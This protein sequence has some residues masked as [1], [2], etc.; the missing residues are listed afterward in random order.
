MDYARSLLLHQLLKDYQ[1][2]AVSLKVLR[3]GCQSE[4]CQLEEQPCQKL[5]PHRSHATGWFNRVFTLY[6][7]GL[8]T[9]D[10]LQIVAPPRAAQLWRDHVAPLDKVVRE[11]AHGPDAEDYVHPVE[12]FWRDYADGKLRTFGEPV[13]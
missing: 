7:F 2:V 4:T 3:S 5:D 9:V 1:D 6:R 8:L 12:V 11:A 10:D 13:N